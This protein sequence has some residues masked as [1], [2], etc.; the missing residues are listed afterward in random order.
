MRDVLVMPLVFSSI[1]ID[2]YER[3]RIKIVS[4]THRTIQVRRRIAD[5]EIHRVFFP[6]DGWR[7]PDTA[8]ERLVEVPALRRQLLLFVRY[9]ALH[10]AADRIVF[11][12][13]AFLPRIADGVEGPQQLTGVVIPC[14]DQTANAVLPAV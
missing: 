8:A 4:W 10:V 6:V 13:E 14:F 5:H 2:C 9:V 7:H 1:K 12:P 3:I 11:C